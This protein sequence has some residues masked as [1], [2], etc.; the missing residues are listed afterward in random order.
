MLAQASG[1]NNINKCVILGEHCRGSS[2]AAKAIEVL[3]TFSKTRGLGLRQA[4]V[5]F[6]VSGVHTVLLCGSA[7]DACVVTVVSWRDQGQE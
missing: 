5:M 4:A 1:I 7:L 3:S 2:V 6:R